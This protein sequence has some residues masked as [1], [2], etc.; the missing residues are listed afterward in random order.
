MPSPV[1]TEETLKEQY[2]ILFDNT[3]CFVAV[4]DRDFRIIQANRKFRETFGESYGRFCY[5]MYKDKTERCPNCPA[6]AA[7]STG[8]EHTSTQTGVDRDGRETHYVVTAT[9]LRGAANG[10]VKA[11]MEIAIDVTRLRELEEEK[12]VA[13]RLAAVGQTVAGLAHGV[14]NVITGLEGGLYVMKSGLKNA[15]VEQLG[16]GL[17]ML[18]NNIE[19]ISHFVKEFLGFA[20]G[21][22]P[23]TQWINPNGVARDVVELY[24][25]TAARAGIAL[26]A[27]FQDFIPE[28]PFDPEGL[29]TCLANL[30]SNALDACAMTEKKDARV[31]VR[32]KKENDIIIFEVTDNGIGMDCEVKKKVFT[33][34]FSTKGSGK[35]TGIGLLITKKI[36]QE[37]GGRVDVV[38]E[39]G[40]G[41]TFRLIFPVSRLPNPTNESCAAPRNQAAPALQDEEKAHSRC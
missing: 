16:K 18:D 10:S 20:K 38:S 37:H 32:T 39:P 29:H 13:E 22:L 12:L 30:V 28:A 3:P 33:N 4:I 7:F 21:R 40:Q 36:V 27:E 23:Q 35:G 2:D 34:F 41:S 1:M 17:S 26:T 11:V 31:I 25:E 15:D 6:E 24:R 8:V 19:R 14:K 5:E 9:P